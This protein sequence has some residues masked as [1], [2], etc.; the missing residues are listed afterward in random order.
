MLARQAADAAESLDYIDKGRQAS[1]ASG[2]SCACLGPHGTGRAV[3]DAAGGR[4]VA[5]AGPIS[6][7]AISASRA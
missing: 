5:A 1:A 6:S 4:G 7:P 3:G 2:R